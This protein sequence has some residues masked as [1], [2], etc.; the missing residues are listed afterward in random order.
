MTLESMTLLTYC[1]GERREQPRSQVLLTRWELILL[2]DAL[3]WPIAEADT[4]VNGGR[5]LAEVA[6]RYLPA[7][8]HAHHLGAP[9]GDSWATHSEQ[10]D[11]HS[12]DHG[13]SGYWLDAAQV[14]RM[15]A[16][17]SDRATRE[18]LQQRL[19]NGQATPAPDRLIVCLQMLSQAVQRGL[20]VHFAHYL[21]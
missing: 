12:D 2:G 15:F 5:H 14:R 7:E 10:G 6:R 1:D 18:A 21:C 3:R 19:T 20:G 8:Q 17:L 9:D 13:D 11:D 16:N 4:T